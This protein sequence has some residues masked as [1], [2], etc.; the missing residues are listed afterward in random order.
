[1]CTRRA[2]VCVCCR[3]A[4]CLFTA[5]YCSRRAPRTHVCIAKSS[6]PAAADLL[7]HL[8][9][10]LNSSWCLCAAWQRELAGTLHA[11]PIFG[12]RKN[13]RCFRR[14]RW[15]K[16]ANRV[17]V[18]K[19]FVRAMFWSVGVLCR[20]VRM[21]YGSSLCSRQQWSNP[22]VSPRPW[23]CW[24]SE[25]VELTTRIWS[26]CCTPYLARAKVNVTLRR[27]T[28]EI[29]AFVLLIT[30]SR[31]LIQPRVRL[32]P[33]RNRRELVYIGME[34]YDLCCLEFH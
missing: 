6:F 34:A 10:F 14:M 3:G 9:V 25:T 23:G 15:I 1:M 22:G 31:F 18:S 17:C 11:V 29:I 32:F 4:L 33:F 16:F 30:Y 26:R 27:K 21:R 8:M 28:W 12:A 5:R 24:D 20:A 19:R 7:Y 13:F 2:S